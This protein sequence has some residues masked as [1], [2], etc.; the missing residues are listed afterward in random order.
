VTI[1]G[2]FVAFLF[3]DARRSLD[4]APS[5]LKHKI[6]MEINDGKTL[7][8][9]VPETKEIKPANLGIKIDDVQKSEKRRNC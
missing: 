5:F 9:N 2:S 1:C 8:N 4:P 3:F 6:V 7:L